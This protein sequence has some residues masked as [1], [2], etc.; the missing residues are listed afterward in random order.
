MVPVHHIF[1]Q[2]I[3]LLL[4]QHTTPEKFSNS[5]VM[6]ASFKAI[7]QYQDILVFMLYEMSTNLFMTESFVDE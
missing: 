2:V 4:L 7:L 3:G 5:T 6:L 1:L